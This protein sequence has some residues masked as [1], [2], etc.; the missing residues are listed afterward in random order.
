MLVSSAVVFQLAL[1]EIVLALGESGDG[2]ENKDC[3]D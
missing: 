1:R 3:D 2:K